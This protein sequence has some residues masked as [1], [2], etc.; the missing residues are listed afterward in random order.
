MF[1]A[2]LNPYQVDFFGYLFQ[3]IS[4]FDQEVNT[5]TRK[6]NQKWASERVQY[7]DDMSYVTTI[8]CI[9]GRV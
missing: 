2:I 4:A 5:L 3:N 9:L 7:I 8:Y 6:N 1:G